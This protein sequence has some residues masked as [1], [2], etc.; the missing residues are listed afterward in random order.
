MGRVKTRYG[1]RPNGQRPPQ[2]WE[3][4]GIDLQRLF[5]Q[6]RVLQ[7]HVDGVLFHVE[8]A[9]EVVVDV[10]VLSEPADHVIAT[11][12][13]SAFP[14]LPW[15]GLR[16]G[17]Y[18]SIQRRQDQ[19]QFLAATTR[20]HT[21]TSSF[22][23]RFL[24]LIGDLALFLFGNRLCGLLTAEPTTWGGSSSVVAAAAAAEDELVVVVIIDLAACC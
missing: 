7:Q 4:A 17:L 10:V 23:R 5:S 6:T 13:I 24:L 8:F 9:R 20:H 14:L 19:I 3:H 12:P 11:D 1:W 15:D 18:R 21:T 16:F 22:G 2:R